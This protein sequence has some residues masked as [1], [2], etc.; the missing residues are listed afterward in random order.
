MKKFSAFAVGFASAC[1]GIASAFMAMGSAVGDV[2][3]TPKPQ[4]QD[5]FDGF[6]KDR[7]T[8]ASDWKKVGSDIRA[9]M[10]AYVKTH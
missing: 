8:L 6:R 5:P 9:G 10:D 2:F 1:T 7:E 3:D 4:T